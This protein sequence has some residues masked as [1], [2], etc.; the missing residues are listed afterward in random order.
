[1][2]FLKLSSEKGIVDVQ[3]VSASTVEPTTVRLSI[4]Q[5]LRKKKKQQL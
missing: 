5:W 2:L 4:D 1:L 3:A